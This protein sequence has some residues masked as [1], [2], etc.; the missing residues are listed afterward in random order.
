VLRF[1]CDLQWAR[2]II[3]SRANFGIG[4]SLTLLVLFQMVLMLLWVHIV[5]L[6]LLIDLLLKVNKFAQLFNLDWLLVLRVVA[7]PRVVRNL[8]QGL[9]L[10]FRLWPVR[11]KR[12]FVAPHWVVVGRTYREDHLVLNEWTALPQLLRLERFRR[13]PCWNIDPVFP[14]WLAQSLHLFIGQRVNCQWVIS[15]LFLPELN[16]EFNCLFIWNAFLHFDPGSRLVI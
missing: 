16:V 9:S 10:R 7:R 6:L 15:A 11:Y 14:L 12:G 13:C 4:L 1:G 3:T 5:R 2:H 8:L